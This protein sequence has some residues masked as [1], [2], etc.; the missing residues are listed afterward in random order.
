MSIVYSR[1]TGEFFEGDGPASGV[2]GQI[3]MR[4][5]CETLEA[6]GE[7]KSTE[8]ITHLEIGGNFIRYRIESY[9]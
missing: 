2:Y 5:L 8:K 1:K 7:I 3:S 4:R 9:K 6:I